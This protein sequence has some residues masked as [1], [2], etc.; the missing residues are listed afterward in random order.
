MSFKTQIDM[1]FSPRPNRFAKSRKV[2]AGVV[3]TSASVRKCF[4]SKRNVSRAS[5]RWFVGIRLEF[6]EKCC[7]TQISAETWYISHQTLGT[8]VEVFTTQWKTFPSN[9]FLLDCTVR[10][11]LFRKTVP[12]SNIWFSKAQIDLSLK[13]QILGY[14]VRFLKMTALVAFWA[15]KAWYW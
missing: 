8:A 13:W 11:E 9:Y 4:P 1:T 14:P 2:T 5:N 12:D 7:F 3:N 6:V 15:W 10:S